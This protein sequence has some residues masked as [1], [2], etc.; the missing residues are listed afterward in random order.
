MFCDMIM[1]IDGKICVV[2]KLYCRKKL[3]GWSCLIEYVLCY[4]DGCVLGFWVG[5]EGVV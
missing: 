2:I 1:V 3:G 5:L 4:F